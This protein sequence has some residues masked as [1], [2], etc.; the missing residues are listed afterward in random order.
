MTN[1]KWPEVVAEFDRI[2]ADIK[3]AMERFE[4]RH[5]A[6]MND[7]RRELA[8]VAAKRLQAYRDRI[9]KKVEEDGK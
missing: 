8:A 6:E 9:A 5:N 2:E 7:M 1:D 3:R 4:A